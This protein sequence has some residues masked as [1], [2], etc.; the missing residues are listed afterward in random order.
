MQPARLLAAFALCATATSFIATSPRFP[1][2]AAPKAA[3]PSPVPSS[4]KVRP[5]ITPRVAPTAPSLV[6]P[7]PPAAGTAENPVLLPPLFVWPGGGILFWWD[8]GAITELR[9][10]NVDLSRCSHVGASAGALAAVLAVCDVD[11]NVAFETA[12]RLTDG[13]GATARGTLLG[14]WGGVCRE[15]LGEI[16]PE[17]AAERCTGTTTIV[18]S[19]L[20]GTFKTTVEKM[21]VS[22]FADRQALIDTLMASVHVPFFMDGKLGATCGEGENGDVFVD[23]SLGGLRGEELAAMASPMVAGTDGLVRAR[24]RVVVDAAA[25]KDRPHFLSLPTMNELR[26]LAARGAAHV[27][28]YD[29]Q[30]GLDASRAGIA[31]A[32]A[33]DIL[34]S[35]LRA[36]FRRDR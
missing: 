27:A 16:L 34:W 13:T 29:E 9:R 35:E 5:P 17:D 24:P 4:L 10:R 6:V 18:V 15:W 28:D 2:L 30:G 26:A 3:V 1:R 23:G 21:P 25:L 22:E 11:M 7:P 36:Y 14:S 31:G 33:G 32:E 19:K 8:A 20:T 12:A